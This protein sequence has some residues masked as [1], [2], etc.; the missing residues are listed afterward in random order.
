M[1]GGSIHRIRVSGGGILRN[2]AAESAKQCCRIQQIC[3]GLPGLS[4]GR[5]ALRFFGKRNG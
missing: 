4:G 5:E 3:N 1:P 2:P